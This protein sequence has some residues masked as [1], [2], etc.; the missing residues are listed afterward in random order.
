MIP[1]FTDTLTASTGG[2]TA[3]VFGEIG[4]RFEFD[5]GLVIEPF[6]NLTHTSV[7]RG[8]LAENGGAAAL[9]GGSAHA[10][11]TT[12]TIGLRGESTFTLGGMTA[13][14]SATLGWR[15][16]LGGTNP[17]TTHGFAT[18]DA[19][20]IAGTPA[21]ESAAVVQVGLDF[22]LSQTVNLNLGYDG[23]IGAGSSSHAV[24]A[25]LSARF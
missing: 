11:L 6:V 1:G 25:S 16:A 20:T 23:S 14:A 12:A 9:G 15:Q 8:A 3:Q 5:S 21:V 7:M 17:T 18:G 22:G 4:Q 24:K 19:F 10:A 2:A 13:A